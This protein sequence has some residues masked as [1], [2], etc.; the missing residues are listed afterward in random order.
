MKIFQTH[1]LDESN[2]P[3][4]QTWKYLTLRLELELELAWAEFIFELEQT[5]LESNIQLCNGYS[6][7][8]ENEL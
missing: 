3:Q 7:N 2:T 4:A 1:E 5:R 8:N 6:L